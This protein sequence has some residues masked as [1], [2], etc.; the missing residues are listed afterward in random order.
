[1]QSINRQLGYLRTFYNVANEFSKGLGK[2]MEQ[3]SISNSV[4]QKCRCEHWLGRKVL[5]AQ[6]AGNGML[7]LL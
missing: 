7:D 3:K 6:F 2:L 1:M 4:R 5:M